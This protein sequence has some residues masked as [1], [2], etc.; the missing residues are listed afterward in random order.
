[1]NDIFDYKIKRKTTNRVRGHATMRACIE[2]LIR[3]LETIK[4]TN[5]EIHLDDDIMLARNILNKRK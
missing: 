3:R 1:M 2:S 4:E 5:P